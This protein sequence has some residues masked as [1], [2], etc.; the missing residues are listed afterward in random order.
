MF[1]LIPTLLLIFSLGDTVDLERRFARVTARD[2]I[3][4]RCDSTVAAQ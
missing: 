3:S 1:R 4:Q 2:R